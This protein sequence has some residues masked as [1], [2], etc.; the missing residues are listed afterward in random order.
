[1]TL[2]DF[3]EGL[4]DYVVSHQPSLLDKEAILSAVLGVL[5]DAQQAEL[6]QTPRRREEEGKEEKEKDEEE[7]E[8]EEDDQVG[9][10]VIVL[11][12]TKSK[13][14]NNELVS[15]TVSKDVSIQTKL[16]RRVT[17]DPNSECFPVLNFVRQQQA[18]EKKGANK[19]KSSYEF[20]VYEQ[21]APN[22]TYAVIYFLTTVV[23]PAKISLPAVDKLDT[24]TNHAGLKTY[25]VSRLAEDKYV[26][27]YPQ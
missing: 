15:I 3:T 18:W 26:S 6:E 17:R 19:P 20:S 7:E 9:R 10:P 11:D 24:R 16:V 12:Q 23:S 4:E 13:T 27:N 5:D 21:N 1:M 14:N 8:E 22:L 25:D 2:T